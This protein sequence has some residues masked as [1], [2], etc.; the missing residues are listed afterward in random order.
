MK[1]TDPLISVYKE[2]MNFQKANFALIDHEDAMVAMVFKV[3]R[4]QEIRT[5]F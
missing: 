5:N 2:R 4:A 1:E 3:T